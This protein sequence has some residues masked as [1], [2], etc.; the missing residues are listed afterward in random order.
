M[1]RT[2][3]LDVAVIES[4]GGFRWYVIGEHY[5]VVAQGFNRSYK[6]AVTAAE[7]TKAQYLAELGV[8]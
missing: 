7:N 5:S 4:Y 8:F 1:I 3:Y 6:R 2:F